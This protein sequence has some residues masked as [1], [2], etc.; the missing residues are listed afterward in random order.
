MSTSFPLLSAVTF[1][2]LVGAIIVMV[3]SRRRPEAVRTTALFTSLATLGFAVALL[4][5]FS[6]RSGGYEFV[7]SHSWS[8][9]LG[10]GYHI[11]VD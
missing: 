11:G 5:Q 2:P 4:V 3:V 10:L 9:Q 6:G 1:T 7:E 8:S